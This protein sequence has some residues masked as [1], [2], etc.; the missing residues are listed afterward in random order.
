MPKQLNTVKTYELSSRAFTLLDSE[1]TDVSAT[2]S[3]STGKHSR[4]CGLPLWRGPTRY[5]EL[6]AW[7]IQCAAAGSLKL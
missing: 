3:A 2:H 4:P 7:L 1:N 5:K 6:C